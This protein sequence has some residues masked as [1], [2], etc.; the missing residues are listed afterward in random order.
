MEEAMM[1]TS[2]NFDSVDQETA[3]DADFFGSDM[4]AVDFYSSSLDSSASLCP[5]VLEYI[6]TFS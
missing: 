3:N 2:S 4:S 5:D 1:S 6:L